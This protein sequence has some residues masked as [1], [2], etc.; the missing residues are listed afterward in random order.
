VKQYDLFPSSVFS[1]KYPNHQSLKQKVLSLINDSV[2]EKDRVSP[3]LFHYKNSNDTSL[4]YESVFKDFKDWVENTCYDYVIQVLGY[5]LTDKII[6]TDSWLNKCNKGGYQ[7]PHY[8][9]NSYISGTYYL[10]FEEGHSP[11]IFLKEST[12]P[13]SSKPVMAL[14]KTNAITQYNSDVTIYPEES[15][16]LLWQS[17]LTHGFRDNIMDNR[18]TISMNFMPTVVTHSKYGYKVFYS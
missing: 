17:S 12:I 6:V 2:L 15:E 16:L 1:I 4:L 3:N 9:S 14:E 11:L 8:H 18:I 13:H 5:Q 7:Y 10:N